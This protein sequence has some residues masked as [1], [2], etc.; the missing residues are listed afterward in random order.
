MFINKSEGCN[1]ITC[2]CRCEFCF[3]CSEKWDTTHYKCQEKEQMYYFDME[4][5]RHPMVMVV[6]MVVFFP[7]LVGFVVLAM[8][9]SFGFM[10]PVGALM[11]IGYTLIKFYWLCCIVIP[12][13]PIGALVGAVM[14]PVL[15]ILQK[16]IPET[17]HHFRRYRITLN[18]LLL[19]NSEA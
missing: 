10:V 6:M 19:K 3:V 5:V 4:E 7:F 2:R 14:L 16:A 12:L 17:I 18:E 11:G 9:A 15:F 1:H 13:L 8:V